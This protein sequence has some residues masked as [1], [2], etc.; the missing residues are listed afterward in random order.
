MSTMFT[1]PAVVT[2]P[3]AAL[4][5]LLDLANA[6][7]SHGLKSGLASAGFS[8]VTDSQLSVFANLDCG[9]TSASEVARR[10]GLSR[11][12]ISRT[13]RDLEAAELVTLEPSPTNSKQKN[14]VMSERGM[15]LA[16]A[17]RQSLSQ[18]EAALAKKIGPKKMAAFRET[19]EM[20]WGDAP[21]FG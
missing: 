8:D 15:A 10:M 7:V 5:L 14:I 19:L 11:Q 6:W 20:A 13:L 17:A 3:P 2:D 18:T 16:N 21:N 9:A 12:G 4:P 1:K